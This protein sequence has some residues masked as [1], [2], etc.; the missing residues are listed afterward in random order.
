MK[1]MLLIG[2]GRGR[3]G[4]PGRGGAAAPLRPDRDLVGRAQG[5]RRAAGGRAA[6]ARQHGDDRAARIAAEVT[7]TDGPFVEGK[8]MIGG[9]GVI[10]VPDLD[11]AIRLASSWPAPDTLEIRPLVAGE[12]G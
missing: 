5:I 6:A 2:G 10:D 12:M 7:V 11:A 8:E 4:S 1:Y 3:L 9:Y